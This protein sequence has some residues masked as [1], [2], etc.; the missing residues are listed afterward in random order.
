MK[1]SSTNKGFKTFF[2]KTFMLFSIVLC[3]QSNIFGQTSKDQAILDS[4]KNKE[5]VVYKT[6]DGIE[7][8][9]IIFYPDASIIKTKNPW[10]LHVHG[11]G[12]AGGDKYKVFRKSF[13]GTLKSLVNK[14]VVCATIEYRR[15]RG[16]STAYEAVVDAKDA[17]R[18]LLKN[19][20]K[21][22]LDK[23]KYG[24][25]GGS[26]GGHLSLLTALGK[27]SDFKGDS[28]LSGISPNFKCVA[29]YFPATSLINPDLVPGSL[30]E[31]QQSYTRILGDSLSNKPK[32]A[33][34][35]SPTEHLE[36][37]SPPILLLHGENDKVLPVINSTFM[38]DVAKE[39]NADVEL[40]IIKNAGHSF[41]GSN[42][43]P[44]MEELNNYAAIFIL[45]HLKK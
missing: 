29:S 42:I 1:K 14:G 20:A 28:N 16:S 19:A 36:A 24:V 27:N 12:W 38:M 37:C 44:S 21:Y 30:F 15:T 10:M 43:S 32:L 23:E 45:S 6:I 5:R 31:K 2:S 7:L 17:A 18:F 3:C 34:L 8:D 11:G 22:K 9:M 40:L 33:K 25:W 26:A 4:F 35:L 41:K 13:L 39:K